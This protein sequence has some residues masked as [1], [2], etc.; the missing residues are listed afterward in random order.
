MM[1][2]IHLPGGMI[3]LCPVPE[4]GVVVT[5]FITARIAR[6]RIFFIGIMY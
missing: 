5:Y 4:N 3:Y 2:I 6:I 1:A